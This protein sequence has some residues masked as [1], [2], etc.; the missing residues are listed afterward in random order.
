ME[1]R[2][3]VWLVVLCIAAGAV[4]A[5]FAAPSEEPIGRG[6]RAPDFS[7][8]RLG[9]AEPVS[10]AGLRGRRRDDEQIRAVDSGV[11]EQHELA[12]RQELPLDLGQ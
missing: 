10:L 4:F 12:W 2:R 3:G 8:P 7:L 9:S 6:S 11:E 1:G 5:L